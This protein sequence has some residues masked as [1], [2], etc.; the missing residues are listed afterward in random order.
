MNEHERRAAEEKLAK[1]KRALDEYERSPEYQR[2]LKPWYKEPFW[3]LFVPA[4]VIFFTVEA[5]FVVLWV[6][7]QLGA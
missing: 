5:V 1:L 7:D 3:V 2:D 4:V 6:I